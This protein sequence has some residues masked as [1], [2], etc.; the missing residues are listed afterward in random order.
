M[1][2]LYN[3]PNTTVG[4]DQILID[5][6]T[7]TPFLSPLILLFVFLVVSVGGIV[8]QKIRNG[9]ADY[10]AWVTLGS[11]ATMLVALLFSVNAGYIRLDWLAIVISLVM[12]S[13]V[14]FF[15]DRKISEV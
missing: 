14:W 2:Y 6:L 8:R 15:L 7:V 13:G 1:A 5:T 9:T 11:I 4:A 12:L 10:P 3:L